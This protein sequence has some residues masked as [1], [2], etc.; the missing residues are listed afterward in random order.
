[1]DLD[2]EEQSREIKEFFNKPIEE[3]VRIFVVKNIG[4]EDFYYQLI[5]KYGNNYDRILKRLKKEFPSEYYMYFNDLI[6][7]AEAD[8]L[9]GDFKRLLFG[10]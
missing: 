6:S 3:R 10:L 4:D 2:F 7:E 1:M 8:D 9:Y 5:N